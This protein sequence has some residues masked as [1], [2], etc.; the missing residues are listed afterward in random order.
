VAEGYRGRHIASKLI[1]YASDQMHRAGKRKLYAKIWHNNKPS[2][3]AFT[4]AGWHW[5]Y[6]FA[7][8]KPAALSTH[9]NVQVGSGRARV[10]IGGPLKDMRG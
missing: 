8:L 7:Q 9:L 6:F 5:S 2:V 10:R 3:R 4:H 1:S